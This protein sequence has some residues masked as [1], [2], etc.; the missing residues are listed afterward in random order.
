MF[1]D[2]LWRLVSEKEKEQIRKEAKAIMDNF[3]KALESVEKQEKKEAGL[4]KRDRQTREEKGAEKQPESFRKI[5]F[6][7]APNK[8]EQEGTITAEKGGWK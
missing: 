7:N 5:F 8:D 2:Y 3:A 4:V 6:K 1:M